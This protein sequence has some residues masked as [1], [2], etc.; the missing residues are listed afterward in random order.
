MAGG[1]RDL[2]AIV[3]GLIDRKENIVNRNTM[4]KQTIRKK[5]SYS[6]FKIE[7]ST[8]QHSSQYDKRVHSSDSWLYIRCCEDESTVA[9]RQSLNT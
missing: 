1:A 3:T 9:A 5:L 4:K 8:I 6:M 2:G 7:A